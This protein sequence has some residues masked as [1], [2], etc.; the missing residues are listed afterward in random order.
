[1]FVGLS[2]SEEKLVRDAWAPIHGDLQGTANT[3][4]YNYLKKYPSNQD[5]FE[6]LKGHPLDE[7]KDT[8]NFKLIAGRI[9]TIFD[10]C[11]KNVGNDKGFQ[12][13][14]ADM[15][16]PHVARPITHGSYNDLRGVIYDSMH[17]DSTHGAAWNKMMDN[18]FYVFY[19]CLDGRCSQF[20]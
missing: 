6:T 15:S 1:A 9:F 16:G 2:D 12:K 10:N 13:V 11:V 14:I 5:K 8:A 7:V 19:E 17:L 20:S 18:F 4:F 3:V